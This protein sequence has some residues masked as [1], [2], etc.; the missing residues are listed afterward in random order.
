[1]T[2]IWKEARREPHT[3]QSNRVGGADGD[4]ALPDPAL[5]KDGLEGFPRPNNRLFMEQHVVIS[6]SSGLHLG[7]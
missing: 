5:G 7:S 1:M 3:H 2:V 4:L 6:L